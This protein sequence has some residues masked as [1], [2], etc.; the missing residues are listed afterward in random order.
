VV[1]GQT[2]G[3]GDTIIASVMDALVPPLAPAN[4]QYDFVGD[5][6]SLEVETVY[7]AVKAL[8]F[9]QDLI[10]TSVPRLAQI[11]ASHADGRIVLEAAA[12][13][14]R[15]KVDDG[16]NRLGEIAR[17]SGAPPAYRMETALILAELQCDRS[18]ELLTEIATNNA[19]E[20]EFRAAAA[21]GLATTKA[22]VARLLRLVD[23]LDE[24]TAVHA[25]VGASRRI[26]ASNI[27]SVL[28]FIGSDAKRSAGTVRAVLVSRVD[29]VDEA[30]AQIRSASSERRPWL[31]YLL[32]AKGR[33]FS[34]ERI[35]RMA[36]ELMTDLEF[37][38]TYH[39]EN[40]TNRLDV[41]DQIDFLRVQT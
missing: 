16:W 23:D 29:F 12:S 2:F 17:D 24:P 20:S 30:I 4:E 33:T 37:F 39:G 25:I 21:W 6:G 22:D 9:F 10:E 35:R 11:M 14:A 18:R 26:D 7:A 28:E 13:L 1:I 34:E 5:L 40:W 8:G 36:P 19:N 38:W 31:L 3:E 27:R 15:L 41:A 32:A